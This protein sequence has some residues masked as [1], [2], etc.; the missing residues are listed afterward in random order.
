MCW[1]VVLDEKGKRHTREVVVMIEDGDETKGYLGET[2]QWYTGIDRCLA[3]RRDDGAHD[4]GDIV[5]NIVQHCFRENCS[6]ER[7]QIC[8]NRQRSELNGK[9]LCLT[10]FAASLI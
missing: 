1:R 3:T 4:V 9:D 6:C 10:D 7:R 2:I 5:W 8:R